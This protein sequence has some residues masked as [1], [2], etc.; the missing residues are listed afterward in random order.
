VKVQVAKS[1]SSNTTPLA[2]KTLLKSP[3]AE[4]HGD[5]VRV[6]NARSGNECGKLAITAA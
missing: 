6:A 2:M 5:Q 1:R 3:N 4:V